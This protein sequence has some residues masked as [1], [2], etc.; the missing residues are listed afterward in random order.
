MI[1]ESALLENRYFDSVFLMR[2][3][4]L[5]SE[6]SGIQQAALVMGTPKNIQILADAVYEGI[7]KL[8]AAPNDLVVCLQAHILLAPLVAP[9]SGIWVRPSSTSP[10]TWHVHRW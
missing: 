1:T 3:S 9:R 6:Q 7:D 8:A 10:G 2:V 5:L 4:K